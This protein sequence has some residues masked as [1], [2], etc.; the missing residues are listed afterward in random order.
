MEAVTGA[1]VRRKEVVT[2]SIDR[3]PGGHGHSE[4]LPSAEHAARFAT[5]GN[6][7]SVAERKKE[8][9]ESDAFPA[10]AAHRAVQR[11]PGPW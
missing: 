7:V 10:L 3:H 8:T 9:N 6:T 2:K 4:V 5:T 11:R 1:S